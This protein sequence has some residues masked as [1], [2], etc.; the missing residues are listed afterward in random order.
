MGLSSSRF[1]LAPLS[2]SLSLSLSGAQ[3]CTFKPKINA[4]SKHQ[5]SS[6]TGS[7]IFTKLHEDAHSR[8]VGRQEEP[9]PLGVTDNRLTKPFL[10][11]PFLSIFWIQKRA[12]KQMKMKEDLVLNLPLTQI[13]TLPRTLSC[14]TCEHVLTTRPLSRA[15]SLSLTHTH[16]RA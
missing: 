11:D 4:K 1:I 16:R 5:L 6:G 14:F 15:R 7:D 3:G 13:L 12:L 10:I 8:S 2:L 9:A